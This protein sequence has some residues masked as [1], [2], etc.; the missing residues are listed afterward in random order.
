MRNPCNALE[1][2]TWSPIR[3][4]CTRRR[5]W[6]LALLTWNS[7]S[8]S[9][10]VAPC[11]GPSLA[12]DTVPACNSVSCCTMARPRPNP[13]W[14]RVVVPSAWLKR[15]NRCLRNSGAIPSPSSLT[16][17]TKQSCS[18][19]RLTVTWPSTGVNLIALDSR[20]DS[21]WR[22]RVASPNT[23]QGCA[24]NSTSRVCALPSATSSCART[25]SRTC[26]ARFSTSTSSCT[27]PSSMLLRSSMSDI[28]FF[29]VIALLAITSMPLRMGWSGSMRCSSSSLQP[30]TVVKGVRSSCDNV[31]RNSSF[32]R[33]MPSAVLRA[34]RSASNNSSRAISISRR[35]VISGLL[36]ARPMK[37]PSGEK[38]GTAFISSQRHCPSWR[39]TRALKCS[40]RCS[41]KAVRSSYSNGASSSACRKRCHQRSPSSVPGTSPKNV[42]K[43][44]LTKRTC[45]RSSSTHTGIGR[46]S[47][48]ALKRASLSASS[49]SMRLRS[50]ISKNSTA[51]W[52]LSSPPMRT[53]STEYQRPS[54]GT[55]R[56]KWTATPPLATLPS[57]WNQ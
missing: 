21:T 16:C 27:L 23:G 9:W 56:S 3:P 42:P 41:A 32:I 7:G 5:G 54:C 18:R 11:P 6:L 53:A 30:S 50:E 10:K 22:R 8:R 44:V 38:R 12:A 19:H 20:F 34:A 17:T 40:S 46:P 29:W 25:A 36:P 43:A 14:R 51:T 48:S 31:A 55:S 52:C 24:G 37:R 1:A 13:P 49:V 4:R 47:A 35:S 15:L 28:R 45:P 57:T 26:S 2:T 33:A 39:R